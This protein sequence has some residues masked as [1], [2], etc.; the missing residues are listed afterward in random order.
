MSRGVAT[1]LKINPP[2]GRMPVLQFCAPGELR[3]DPAYQRSCDAGDSQTLIRR[4]A[5][6]WNWDLCQPL[7]VS[8]RENS[9]LF[10]I[11]GQHR[12]EAARLRGDIAQ[13]PCVVVDCGSAAAE[14]AS[15]VNLNQQRRPLS[16][17]DLFRASIAGNDPQATAISAAMTAA[18]LSLAPHGNY[19]SWKPGMVS[20]VGGIERSWTRDGAAIAADALMALGQGFTGQVLRYCGTIYRG[21]ARICRDEHRAHGSFPEERFTRFVEMLSGQSQDDWMRAINRYFAEHPEMFRAEAAEVLLQL[22]WRRDVDGGKI[23]PAAA[24]A[25]RPAARTAE[26]E[27]LTKGPGFGLGASDW[28]G[29]E[30]WVWCDQC[31]QRRTQGQVASCASPFCKAKA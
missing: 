6:N 20:H 31:D 12:L 16:K 10:V 19:I 4:I 9:A 14:A 17:L 13:L 5:V 29:D 22:E 25:S 1:R 2:V 28:Q 21:I 30:A 7:V 26:P 8:R 11:D 15:F 18:G 27:S 23:F 24:P 3:V